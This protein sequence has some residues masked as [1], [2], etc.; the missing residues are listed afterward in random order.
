MKK[1]ILT[2][3]IALLSAGAMLPLQSCGDK[4]QDYPWLVPDKEN[5]DDPETKV[6]TMDVLEKQMRSGI[7]YM[8]NYS[9]EPDGS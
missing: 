6:T 3:C 7:P 9:H 2:S 1:I 5:V 8:L 4:L